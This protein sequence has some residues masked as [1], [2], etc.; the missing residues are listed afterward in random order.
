MQGWRWYGWILMTVALASYMGWRLLGSE[1]QSMYLVG[2]TT[3]GHHQIE[4][5]CSSC[6]LNPFGGKDV[7]QEACE[8][9]HLEELA[10]IRDSHPRRKFTDPA[11]AD[12]LA[13]LDAR[14]CTTC[15]R[16]HQEDITS[17][18]GLTV[19]QDVCVLCHEKIGEE[20]A[21]HEGMA[22]TSC[23][24]SGCHNFHDNTAL[25]ESF[26]VDNSGHDWLSAS[27]LVAPLTAVE[28]TLS[29][30][31][32]SHVRLG[33][34]QADAPDVHQQNGII[35]TEWATSAHALTN[36]NCSGC[37]ESDA[38]WIEQPALQACASCHEQQNKGFLAG[39]HGMR[40]A[41]G[42]P[43]MTPAEARIPMKETAAHETLGCTSCHDSHTS[44][45]EFA[46]VDACLG[47]HDS[48]HTLAYEQSPH[49]KLRDQQLAGALT[50][51]A[52]VTCATCH[53]PR[54]ESIVG[55]ATVV[56]VEHNQNANLRPSD[57]MLRSVCMDCHSLEFSMDALADPLLINNNF[58]GR[59]SIHVQSVDMAVQRKQAR[60][61]RPGI[62]Q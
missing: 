29:S 6:H 43:A 1:D 54:T 51:E 38:D 12:R 52:V 42:L 14:F 4:L 22:F 26:L 2:K 39:K 31:P 59:P 55:G 24:S 40:L 32:A 46:A 36:V 35:V 13:V 47:C 60:V 3:D 23:S 20:R 30:L 28:S 25:Y 62:A 17:T 15:H 50:A 8:N 27:P 5:A 34:A 44:D 18:M 37:H 58:N 19:P 45:R 7:L 21:T 11:N 16:E 48:S 9:C 33:V 41:V 53:M 56:H 49:A 10:D 61:K 57:K